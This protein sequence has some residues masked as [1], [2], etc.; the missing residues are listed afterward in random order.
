M[1]FMPFS[2]CARTPVTAGNLIIKKKKT[3]YQLAILNVR[4]WKKIVYL[5]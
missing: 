2:D 5:K 3:I 4:K 1:T